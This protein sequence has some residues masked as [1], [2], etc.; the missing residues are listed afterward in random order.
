MTCLSTTEKTEIEARIVTLQAQLAL[1]NDAY[2]DAMT[3][4]EDYRLDTGEGAQR[5][6]R[7]KL[8]Q[9]LQ[10][11]SAIESRIDWYRR[12]LRGTGVFNMNLRRR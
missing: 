6:K 10:S 5:V 8:A 12:K 9:M 1:A 11:I 2:D 3:A 4:A 7:R